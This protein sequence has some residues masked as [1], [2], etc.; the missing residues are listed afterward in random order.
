MTWEN[1][2]EDWI[3]WLQVA[4]R[5]GTVTTRQYWISRFH[6]EHRKTFLTPKDVTSRALISWLANNTWEPQTRRSVAATLRG[7]FNWLADHE[8][9]ETD[10]SVRIPAIRVPRGI[11][12]PVPR[13]LVSRALSRTEDPE[14]QRMIAL[15]V[16]AGLRRGEITTLHTAN[17][18][19]TRLKIKGKGGKE[20][21]IPIHDQ[22]APYL[23][24]I[25]SGY[26]FPGRYTGH[27]HNDFIGKRIR[28]ALGSPWHT[29]SL[30]HRFA[31]DVYQAT[32]D[33]RAVQQLLGHASISTTEVYI[34]L[35]TDDL[36]IAVNHIPKY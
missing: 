12:S 36:E 29:H 23:A 7:F 21:I 9:L 4:R 11:P 35:M 20:R 10:P 8:E 18:W 6:K 13:E 28:T 14:L 27:R 3:E 17:L 19:G 2:I 1:A 15:G 22:L 32:R 5:E 24:E 16:F 25:P 34:M 33:I 31:T 26:F 30:R